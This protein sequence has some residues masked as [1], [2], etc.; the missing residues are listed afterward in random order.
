MAVSYQ[1]LIISALLLGATSTMLASCGRRGDLDKP[2]TAVVDQ[3]KVG[4][5]ANAPTPEKKFF[6]D[7][8]L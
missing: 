8:L 4:A 7:P 3:N 6:L 2:S 1:K 5:P